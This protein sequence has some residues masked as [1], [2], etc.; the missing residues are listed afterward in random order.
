MTTTEASFTG[1]AAA[2]A[3]DALNSRDDFEPTHDIDTVAL[4]TA[5]DARTGARAL[6]KR[7]DALVAHLSAGGDTATAEGLKVEIRMIVEK[8]DAIT[9]WAL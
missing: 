1:I 8:L 7:I 2:D 5:L 6:G 9:A 4:D 3:L